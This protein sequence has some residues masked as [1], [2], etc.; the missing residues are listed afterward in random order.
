MRVAQASASDGDASLADR[1]GEG[2]NVTVVAVAAA[3]EDRFGRR[4]PAFGALGER[5][6]GAL[7]ALGLF[8]LASARARTS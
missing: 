3:V 5:L 8:E 6:A 7:R 2:A 1:F 4:P